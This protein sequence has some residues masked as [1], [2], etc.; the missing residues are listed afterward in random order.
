[1]KVVSYYSVVPTKNK[2]QEKY[3]ILTKFVQGVNAAGDTGILHTGTD[4]IDADVGVIQGWQ[5]ERGKNAPHL[6]LRQNVIDCTK[7]RHVLSAD[8]NLF[9]YTNPSNKPHHYLR[10]SLDGIFPHTGNYFDDTI[11][12]NRWKQ[13]SKDCNLRLHSPIRQGNHILICAQ[14]DGGWSMGGV[15][16][17]QW[18]TDTCNEVRKFSGRHIVVRLHPKDKQSIKQA[19]LIQQHLAKIKNVS[20]SFNKT[21]GDDLKYTWAVINHNSSSIVGPIIHGYHA[22]ITDP[23]SSQCAEVAHTDFSKIETPEEFDRQRWLERISMFHWKFSEL[24][25][26]T[27]WRHMRDYCFQ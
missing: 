22:F 18:L 1:M 5:H 21:L 13:I 3:D 2:S 26:G 8:S 10:Y 9:L 11:D 6:R 16:L 27:A 19:R 14:R 17:L 23:K 12:T 15:S 24:E 20:L 7:N 4:L 25:D